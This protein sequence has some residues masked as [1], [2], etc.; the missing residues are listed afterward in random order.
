MSRNC[1][2]TTYYDSYL[3]FVKTCLISFLNSL[4]NRNTVI[5][6]QVLREILKLFS[7]HFRVTNFQQYASCP[8]HQEIRKAAFLVHQE[9]Q[10]RVF[11]VLRGIQIVVFLDHQEI[12]KLVF[13]DHQET[14]KVFFQVLLEIQIHVC[15][16]VLESSLVNRYLLDLKNSYNSKTE[17]KIQYNK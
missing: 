15:H 9:I 10:K 16:I 12:Q 13:L 8:V 4:G 11:L 7:N 6:F 1:P 2:F 3:V 14:R 17:R 5:V